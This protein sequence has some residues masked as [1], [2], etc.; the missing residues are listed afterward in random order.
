MPEVRLVIPEDLDRA[1]DG[2]I[3]AGFAGNK[4]ELARTALTHFQIGRAHV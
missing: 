4:A 3:K 1:L 2:L